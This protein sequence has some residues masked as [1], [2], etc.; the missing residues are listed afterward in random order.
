MAVRAP[1][2][3]N[4]GTSPVRAVLIAAAGLRA[5]GGD[6]AVMTEQAIVGFAGLLR[7]LRAG[8]QLTQ[9]ELAKAAA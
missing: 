6:A 2:L 3:D 9:Q 8:A 7:Q 1:G 5:V 4:R